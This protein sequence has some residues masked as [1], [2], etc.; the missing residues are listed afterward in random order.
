MTDGNTEAMEPT[1]FSAKNAV[2]RGVLGSVVRPNLT[3][4][5]SKHQTG[6]ERCEAGSSRDIRMAD[7][8][9]TDQI[10]QLEAEIERLAGVAEGCRKVILVSK[11]VVAIGGLML[12]ATIFRLIPFDQLVMVGSIAAVLGGIVALGSNTTTLRQA[13]ADMRAA[14]ALRSELIDRLEFLAVIEGTKRPAS[15]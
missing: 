12:L 10:S 14:E 3:R 9:L 1:V 2:S 15:G 13:T 11:A 4:S 8:E 5:W 7:D 6:G